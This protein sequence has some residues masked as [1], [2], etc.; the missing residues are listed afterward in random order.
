MPLP[1]ALQQI[2]EDF[3]LSPPDLRLELLLEHSDGLPPLP[4]GVDADD[5]EQVVECQTPFFVHTSVDEDGRVHLAFSA[6]PEA[7][8]TRGFAG[9]LHAG[10]DGS[11]VQEVLQVE[12]DFTDEMRLAEVISP[13]RMN[14]MRAVLAR[15]QRQ[16][17][18]AATA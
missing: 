12:P 16:V 13:L 11:T 4:D 15:L 1:L 7:P 10:L 9:I 8:T 17:R 5:M 18:E 2:V 3:A 14:G 6:P